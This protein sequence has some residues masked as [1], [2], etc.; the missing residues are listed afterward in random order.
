VLE[1]ILQSLREVEGV[2]GAMVVDDAAAVV[3]YRAHPIYD[4]VSVLYQVARSVLTA[5]ESVQLVQDDWDMLTAQFG[6][7]KLLLRSLR[8]TQA[9]RYILTVIADANLNLAFL[10]VAL[11]VAAQKLVLELESPQASQSGP[12]PVTFAS[13][14]TG[15]FPAMD[16]MRAE[17][18]RTGTAWGSAGSGTG[19]TGGSSAGS[20]ARSSFA[21]GS[22][23]S[24]NSGAGTG[25]GVNPASATSATS[26]DTGV[27]D[28]ASSTFLSAATKALAASVGPMA[29]VFVKEAVRRV[30]G[31]RPFSRA[32]GPAVLAHLASTIDDT[33]DRAMFQRATRTL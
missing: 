21:A 25:Y 27:M 9:R 23:A 3:G 17:Q 16:S 6:E 13:G 11:R 8:T 4:D 14:S 24:V 33:D 26:A 19:V 10:G 12:I 2:Q 28:A 7:G 29:K 22:G 15:R 32:D 1:P 20:S 30:C 5:V 31:E 18:P